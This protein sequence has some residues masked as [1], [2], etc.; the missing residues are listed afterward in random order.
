MKRREKNPVIQDL[1]EKLKI[2]ARRAEAP[3]WKDIAR[4]LEKPRRN[5]AE[6]NV[7][8][9]ERYAKEGETIV[10]PGKLLGSGY[11]EKRITVAAASCSQMARQKIKEAGGTVKT[12]QD[13]MKENPKGSGVRIMG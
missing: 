6:V 5:W 9:L 8:H 13:I 1:I 12:F 11:I 2:Q 4:R 7:G 10:I 3:I